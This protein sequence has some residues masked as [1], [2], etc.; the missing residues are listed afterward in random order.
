MSQEET[1]SGGFWEEAEDSQI[2]ET[3]FLTKASIY[4]LSYK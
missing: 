4:F 2:N 1:L 3:V